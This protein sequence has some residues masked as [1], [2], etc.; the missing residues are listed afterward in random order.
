M[1]DADWDATFQI[2]LM[3]AVRCTKAALPLLRGERAR[4]GGHG[5]LGHRCGHGH[6]R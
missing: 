4:T 1:T 3:A 2:G 5:H 6:A